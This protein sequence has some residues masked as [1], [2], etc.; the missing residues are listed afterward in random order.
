[1]KK[2]IFLLVITLSVLSIHAETWTIHGFRDN[3]AGVQ[4]MTSDRHSS[5]VAFEWDWTW[6]QIYPDSTDSGL[7]IITSDVWQRQSEYQDTITAEVPYDQT[8]YMI[9]ISGPAPDYNWGQYEFYPNLGASGEYWFDFNS[10]GTMRW[11]N[12]EPSDFG[13]WAWDGTIN[14]SWV[15]P[16]VVK[17]KKGHRK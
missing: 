12:S 8:C 16:L 1:M 13:K 11:A 2:L 3:A 7:Y 9:W 4:F 10:D 6:D 15:E 17:G 5:G 14:P